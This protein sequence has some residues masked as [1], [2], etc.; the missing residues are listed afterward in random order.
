MTDFTMSE[1]WQEK[2][3]QLFSVWD[4]KD[5]PGCALG[6][7]KEGEFIFQTGYGLAD[8]D[9]GEEINCQT[10]FDLESGSKQF[11]AACIVILLGENRLSLDDDIRVYFPE[12]FE[13]DQPI[14]IRHVL[15]HTS[16][17]RHVFKLMRLSGMD[18]SVVGAHSD[19]ELLTLLA[20]QKRPNFPA[21]EREEYNGSNYFLLGQL[22]K[23]ITGMPLAEYA[24]AHIFQPLGMHHTYILDSPEKRRLGLAK[25]YVQKSEGGY[26]EL[27]GEN[28]GTYVAG[29]KG[30]ITNVEDL[31][32]WDQN[33]YH[34]KLGGSIDLG[35]TLTTQSQLAN[36]ATL[37]RAMGLL[38]H[39]YIGLR[40]VFGTGGERGHT[41]ELRR[42]PD[43]RFSVICLSNC[44]A[45]VRQLATEVADV[46]LASEL[47]FERF[48]G[49][50][51]NADL[52]VTHRIIQEDG[53]LFLKGFP[54]APSAPLKA[55]PRSRG[56]EFEV[57]DMILSFSL[58]EDGCT[59][60][61]VMHRLLVKGLRFERVA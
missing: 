40:S 16:G 27:V 14:T 1:G 3:D 11:T 24:A 48:S 15:Y 57:E 6:I 10:G 29:G 50:Y 18:A 35:T 36:G 20:R 60:T 12:F 26:R 28:A 56:F 32:K 9:S 5:M 8:L 7:I 30:L 13:F 41:T 43:L 38:C 17:L 53:K 61:Y 45:P 46:C 22:V 59:E 19:D 52:D 47:R 58:L 25:K 23:R 33:F 55:R 4:T 49:V 31:L 42:F 44:T 51:F 54:N 37:M 2:V 21:G 39:N 34:D